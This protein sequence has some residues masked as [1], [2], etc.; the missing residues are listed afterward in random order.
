MPGELPAE[1]MQPRIAQMLSYLP[2]IHRGELQQAIS[3]AH[4]DSGKPPHR[5]FARLKPASAHD[6]GLAHA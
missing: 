3:L 2:Y 5:T 1:L 4:A 6:G